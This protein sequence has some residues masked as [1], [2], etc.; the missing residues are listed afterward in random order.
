MTVANIN[1]EKADTVE[2]VQE[3]YIGT[4]SSASRKSTGSSRCIKGSDYRRSSYH[5]NAKTTLAPLIGTLFLPRS[6]FH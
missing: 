6:F 4:F 1:L 2:D 3:D 5:A